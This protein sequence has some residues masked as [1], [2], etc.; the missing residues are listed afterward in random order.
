MA[1]LMAYS[2]YQAVVIDPS[3]QFYFFQI[4]STIKI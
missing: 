2:P 4:P 3:I 1:F